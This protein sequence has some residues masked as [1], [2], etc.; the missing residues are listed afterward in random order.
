MYFPNDRVACDA[1]RQLGGNLAGAETLGPHLLEKFNPLFRPGELLGI[2]AGNFVF[3]HW[4]ES[5]HV[6]RPSLATAV[7][8]YVR[9]E[10]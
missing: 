1:T 10:Y 6:R 3:A 4:V 5:F 8:A 7:N 9:T 2:F